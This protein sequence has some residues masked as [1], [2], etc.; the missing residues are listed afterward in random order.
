MKTA[1][2]LSM[3]LLC[4]L[5]LPALANPGTANDAGTANDESNEVAGRVALFEAGSAKPMK[6][7]SQVVV[8]LV[9][10]DAATPRR[11][12][13]DRP[14]FRMLQHDK[15]FEPHLLVVPL[16]SVV[17]FPN[18]DPWFHNVFS[19]YQGKR[20]DLGLYEAGSERTVT[21]D[22]PG[23]SFLFCNI[24]PQMTAVI[25]AVDSDY[26]GVSTKTGQVSIGNVPPGKYIL[27]AWHEDA[28]PGT[29][30]ALQRQVS[31][32]AAGNTLPPL[33]IQVMKRDT[34][35]KDMYGRDYDTAGESPAY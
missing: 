19:L 4:E 33:S 5:L 7:A 32:G 18:L 1:R 17:D 20:F 13:S 2:L 10:V 35:H 30:S 8:W 28:A 24:H 9:P 31:L 12:S 27:H 26:F 15:M 25:M 29:L 6:D 21:F 34:H 3:L 16:R 11:S 23:P 14:H 22:R